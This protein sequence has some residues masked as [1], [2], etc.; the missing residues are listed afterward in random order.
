MSGMDG[1]TWRRDDSA[2]V[3][4][5]ELGRSHVTTEQGVFA[6]RRQGRAIGAALGVAG[7]DE[8][9]IAAALSEVCRRLLDA[10]GSVTVVFEI[11][12][13]FADNRRSDRGRAALTLRASSAGTVNAE[14]VEGVRVTKGLMDFWDIERGEDSTSVS[15]G[16]I[17]PDS[18]ARL[19]AEA[20]AAIRADV[21]HL[22][23]GT[24]MEELAE[25]NRQLL[26]TLD[27]VQAHRDELLRL[28]AELEDT[29]RG[30]LALYSE[31]SQELEATNRGVVALYAELDQRTTQLRG[32]SEAKTRFLA[33]VSHELRSPVTSIVGLT[34]LLRDPA[35]DP[36]SEEQ[37]HQLELIDSSA[38]GLLALVNDL[39]DL[40]K[41]ESGRLEPR[42]EETD[43]RG[44]FDTLRGTARAMPMADQTEL[45]VEDPGG[46]PHVY[47]DPIMV[48]QI[49]RNLLTNGIKFTPSG[50]VR[51]TALDTGDGFVELTVTDTG[52][53]I[54]TDEQERVFEEFHQVPNGLQIATKGTGLGLPYA[55]RLVDILGG[56]IELVS[57]P[58]R[59]SSFTVRLPIGDAATADASEPQ[60]AVLLVDDDEAFRLAARSVLR[61]C[62]FAVAE[63][64]DGR[65]A[66]AAA[67][68]NPPDIILLDLRL[69]Q[70]DGFAVLEVLASHSRLRNVPVIVVTAYPDAFLDHPAAAH[71]TAMF[72][73]A[74]ATL[75]DLCA[76]IHETVPTRSGS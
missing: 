28:N 61:G 30:V 76:V 31:L 48:T 41:A 37:A 1:G 53:G 27:E 67:D 56:G 59:G 42:R 14:F 51:M 74:G 22:T 45:V 46:V 43:L 32:A 10:T 68:A 44:I 18:A 13:V 35:S 71:A 64:A 39:L 33:N 47:T 23:A 12:R 25:H 52:I 17:L 4:T 62:G 15:M 72:D 3:A 8:I 26:A 49:L 66:L 60:I 55:R 21:A 5:I 36:L 29:N 6:V 9:R 11:S 58:G 16:R 73:K 2:G 34:R 20:I 70:I 38:H 24:P 19:S 69:E 75:D 50:S 57:E 7:Q 63:A 40:A 54:P 65:T